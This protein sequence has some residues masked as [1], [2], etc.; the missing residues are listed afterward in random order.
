MISIHL[1]FQSFQTSSSEVYI[2][3]YLSDK[4][5]MWFVWSWACIWCVCVCVCCAKYCITA[6]SWWV[7]GEVETADPS[8]VTLARMRGHRNTHHKTW[9]LSVSAAVCWWVY[10]Y[11]S[12]SKA[13]WCVC[14]S[15]YVWA[16]SIHSSSHV[17]ICRSNSSLSFVRSVKLSAGL[18]LIR[19]TYRAAC[20]MQHPKLKQVNHVIPGKM[21]T[22]S[23]RSKHLI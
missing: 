6:V 17:H 18:G 12:L 22:H 8:R 3:V 7:A 23:L 19:R 15:M 16:M 10:V 4:N 14:L 11:L 5:V 21:I 2:H 13:V 20:N 9:A 1:L